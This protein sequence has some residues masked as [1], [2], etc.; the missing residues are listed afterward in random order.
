MV[1]KPSTPFFQDNADKKSYGSPKGIFKKAVKLKYICAIPS[2]RLKSWIK[3]GFMKEIEF[4]IKPE[5][6]LEFQLPR[7]VFRF[8]REHNYT[9]PIET[10]KRF[11]LD[12]FM[13]VPEPDLTKIW[14]KYL[15]SNKS[16]KNAKDFVKI[17]VPELWI[18]SEIPL[19]KVKISSF[20]NFRKK[21]KF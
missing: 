4:F 3:S 2:A 14:N 5:Y 15:K 7:K 16:F 13:K 9:S 17:K 20:D 19:N 8:V 1:L 6:A 10:K 12:Q 18:N 21:H 11:G